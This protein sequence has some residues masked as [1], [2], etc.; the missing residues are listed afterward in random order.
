LASGRVG[1][2]A[3]TTLMAYGAKKSSLLSLSIKQ[4]GPAMRK[5]AKA[6]DKF[7]KPEVAKYVDLIVV[8][9]N[10]YVLFSSFIAIM[11]TCWYV[12]G[13]IATI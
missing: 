12:I 1:D 11:M 6:K 9:A 13:R 7:C 8:L 2:A 4:L 5:R 3:A 10:H